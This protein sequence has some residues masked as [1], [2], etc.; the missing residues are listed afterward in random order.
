MRR[1][2]YSPQYGLGRGRRMVACMSLVSSAA[3]RVEGV[4][5]ADSLMDNM[6]A[7]FQESGP[8]RTGLRANDE[9]RLLNLVEKLLSGLADALYAVDVP[10]R[11]IRMGDVPAFCRDLMLGDPV[12]H[13]RAVN[14]RPAFPARKE[15]VHFVGNL[16]H[17]VLDVD[18][19]VAVIGGGEEQL[20]VVVQKHETHV[21]DGADPVRVVKV[22]VP[23]LQQGAQSGGPAWCERGDHG[24]L[25]DLALTAAGPASAFHP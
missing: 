14:P 15:D 13:L 6:R 12:F 23:Q 9:R 10:H 17:E 1:I 19:P 25:R 3:E 21:V 8:L 22:A 16:R 5:P 18:V 4:S 7:S 11:Q 2:T 20:G 24:Q